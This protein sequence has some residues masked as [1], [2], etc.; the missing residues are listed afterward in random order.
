MSLVERALRDLGE[1]N[2]D[3]VLVRQRTWQLLSR[4]TVLMPRLESPDETDWSEVENK[5]IPVARGI[6]LSGA[7]KLRDRLLA[8]ASDYSPRAAR[9]DLTI[10]RRD[11]HETLDTN[12][13][14]YKQGW[15]ILDHLHG[16]ALQSLR[17]EVTDSDRIRRVSLD[18]SNV[19][20]RLIAAVGEA[21]AVVV[22]GESGVGKSALTIRALI[23]GDPDEMGGL[24]INLRHIPRL[25]V[26]FEA[27]LG[28][29]LFRLLSELSAP[30]R[31]LVIDGADAVAEGIEDAFRYL[32]RSAEV[33]GVKVVAVSG[34]DSTQV[35]YDILT[36]RFGDSV[37]RFQVEPL[38][39]TEIDE[40]VETF[41][42]LKGLTSNPQSR[43]LLRRLVVTDLLVRGQLR[44]VPLSDA[45]AMSEVWAGLVRRHERLDRGHPDARQSVL[46]RLADL[47]LNGGDWLGVIGQLDTTAITGLRQDGLL[48]ASTENPFV[49]G[50]DFAHDE[51]RRYSVARLLLL[52]RD[53][54]RSILRAKA[55]RGALGAARLACQ[56]LLQEPDGAT[57]PIRG[58]FKALQASFDALVQAGFGTRWGDLPSEA[59]ISLADTSEVLRDAW[60]ELQSNEDAGLKRLVRLV[61]Q[62]PAP[63]HP[64]L[65]ARM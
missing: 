18:R 44:G 41:P 25:A 33:I 38:T 27:S 32:V 1:A 30:L 40:M 39:D 14:R 23:A 24:C 28:L 47:S 20:G 19:T 64:W 43:E 17:D 10:L 65:R 31:M 15:Q 37:A 52:E 11:A 45:D 7:K 50:P 2:P 46:L 55:P 58:R 26:D 35:V 8:L 53:P 49:S 36:D 61:E 51:V 56:T 48:Q 6:S 3:A 62:R 29:P 9:V 5:L 34:M 21:D 63:L 59:L 42:E 4:L 22:V 54:A 60:G 13:R 16:S 57:S 12:Y